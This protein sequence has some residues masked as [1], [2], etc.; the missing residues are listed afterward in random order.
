MRNACSRKPRRA[1]AGCAAFI[2]TK[3]R[4]LLKGRVNEYNAVRLLV[5]WAP[6]TVLD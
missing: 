6:T 4:E 3:L 2:A 1:K 5:T